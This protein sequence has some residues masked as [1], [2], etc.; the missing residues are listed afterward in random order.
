M[1]DVIVL[2]LAIAMFVL[3]LSLFASEDKQPPVDAERVF[4][5]KYVKAINEKDEAQL[6]QLMHP[7]SR[8]C[9]NSSN[10]DYFNDLFQRRLNSAFVKDGIPKNYV[11]KF[12]ELSEEDG[13]STKKLEQASKELGLNNPVRPTHRLQIDFNRDDG[14]YSSVEFL[15]RDGDNFYQVYA[16]PTPEWIEEYRK[17]KVDKQEVLKYDKKLKGALEKHDEPLSEDQRKFFTKDEYGVLYWKKSGDW[18]H[19]WQF[20]TK[21]NFK[22]IQIVLIDSDG[23]ERILVDNDK[24]NGYSPLEFGFRLGGTTLMGSSID[25]QLSIPFGYSRVGSIENHPLG[26][27]DWAILGGNSIKDA[28]VY[29]RSNS[30]ADP[31]TKSGEIGLATYKTSDDAQEFTSTIKIK[32]GIQEE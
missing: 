21:T 24:M 4:V 30:A 12:W 25:P 19:N 23:N 1:R 8:K 22:S 26:L 20:K 13:E 5:E 27:S 7:E 17:R 18:I 16:C 29:N 9:L 6:R 14:P 3:P 28:R 10:E 11:F 31:F 32:Y 2:V 15:A